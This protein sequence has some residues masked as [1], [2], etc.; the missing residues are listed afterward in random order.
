MHL[1]DRQIVIL[2]D[3]HHWIYYKKL[4][5]A[6]C[7]KFW[8]APRRQFGRRKRAKRWTSGGSTARVIAQSQASWPP[9]RNGA[10]GCDRGKHAIGAR[11]R[12]R[13][14]TLLRA[15][16]FESA[17]STSS[18]TRAPRGAR[19]IAEPVATF[20]ESAASKQSWL[21]SPTLTY[22]RTYS[23]AREAGAG[24]RCRSIWSESKSVR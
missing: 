9:A 6:N 17:A 16:D 5:C 7:L 1:Y 2:H 22:P 20:Q 24:G 4:W 21:D 15:A 10:A 12:S 23:P 18:A 3:L 13:T 8:L 14:D 19:S 11:G